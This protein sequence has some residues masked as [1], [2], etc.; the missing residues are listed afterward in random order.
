MAKIKIEAP[1][2]EITTASEAKS[3]SF[4]GVSAEIVA[5]ISGAIAVICG[6]DAKISGI[7]RAS[8]RAKTSGR[9]AWSA[10][11]LEDNTRAF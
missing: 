9:S 1:Y 5:A 3:V 10:A 7:S 4:K 11:G 6:N 2:K 8:R